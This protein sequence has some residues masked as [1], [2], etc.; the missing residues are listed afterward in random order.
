MKGKRPFA[1]IS[2]DAA[3]RTVTYEADFW[4]GPVEAW[5]AGRYRRTRAVSVWSGS[6]KPIYDEDAQKW[7]VGKPLNESPSLSYMP[8][9][10]RAF[11][12]IG[13]RQSK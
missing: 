11:A 13:C 10:L 3:N 8:E 2:T 4:E 9:L 6:S 5:Q 1:L 7:R 12:R